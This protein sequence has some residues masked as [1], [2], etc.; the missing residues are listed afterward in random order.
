[1]T[2][3]C[4]AKILTP[5]NTLNLF[6]AVKS[7]MSKRKANRHQPLPTDLL[8]S[9]VNT[10]PGMYY[11]W[12]V[13]P[14]FTLTYCSRGSLDLL[15]YHHQ[16]LLH[17]H[18]EFYW[19]L[20]Y[21][22]DLGKVRQQLDSSSPGKL[23]TL[24]FRVVDR[25]GRIK[26]LKSQSVAILNEAGEL[27]AREGYVFEVDP[28]S[29]RW[30]LLNQL[31]AY[32]DAIEVN[33]ISSVTDPRGNIIYANKNF[34]QISQYTLKELV[35]Q[36]HRI[37]C[38]GYHPASFFKAMWNSISSGKTWTGEILNKAKDGNLYWVNTVIIPVL[39]HNGG[40]A[41]YLSLRQLITSRKEAEF[42][43]DRYVQI[44]EEIANM[45]AHS[46]RGPLCSIMGLAD[47]IT[48]YEN[49]PE[50]LDQAIQH[51]RTATSRLDMLTR[52]LSEKV[53]ADEILIKSTQEPDYTY[54]RTKLK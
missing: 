45:V 15:G 26:N 40:I 17:Q 21:E 38:S 16:D 52:R 31:K 28:L 32:R 44:L 19:E 23:E 9:L 43:R 12:Q 53:Y 39:D 18:C 2:D 6:F 33:I 34:C 22:E 7:Y 14:F 1:V 50:V 47:L 54:S 35:G 8:L 36:N 51:L 13:K 24:S 46:M 30:N 4:H 11:H 27:I 10:M 37:I 3:F 49:P 5:E 29:T 25:Q 48:Q 20:I 42:Q 41:S